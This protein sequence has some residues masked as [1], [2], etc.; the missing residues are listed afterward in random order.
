V[1]NVV[2]LW[3]GAVEPAESG[4][5]TGNVVYLYKGAVQPAAT[6]AAAFMDGKFT[7]AQWFLRRRLLRRR[8]DLIR[9]ADGGEQLRP[10]IQGSK[11]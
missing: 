5:P 4:S 11:V 10:L 2:S 9:L 8:R 6:A 3:K 1:A 7:E